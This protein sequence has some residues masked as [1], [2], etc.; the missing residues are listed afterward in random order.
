MAADL[1]AKSRDQWRKRGY[2]VENG[3]Y[4]MRVPGGIVRRQDTF[5]FADLIAIPLVGRMV[6]GRLVYPD[7]VPRWIYIQ[8]TSW[9]NVSGR[10]RKIKTESTGRGKHSIPIRELAA[11][12]L[13]SGHK[14]VIEGW[15]KKENGRYEVKQRWVGITDLGFDQ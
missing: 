3:E 4:I 15:R 10:L 9:D 7:T 6:D 12:V 14:I 13:R 8:S 2:H 1:K 5:G 11:A